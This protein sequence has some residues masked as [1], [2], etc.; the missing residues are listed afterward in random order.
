MRFS[1]DFIE[2]VSEGNNLVDIISQYT[3]LKQSGSGLMGR[4]PFPDHAEKTASFSVSEVKQVYHCFGCHKSGNLFS[5]LRDYQGMSFPEAVEY[6]ANRAS[7]PIPAP[8]AHDPQRDQAADKKKSL[9]KVNKLAADYFSEQ[10]RRVSND[11]PVKRYIASRG[12]SQ[13]VIDTFGIGYAI[14]EWD[15]LERVLQSKQ[16]PMALAEEA[17]LVKARNGKPGYFDIF[18]DRLMFPIFSP[19]GEPIAFGGRYLEKK[20]TEPKY[21]NSPETPVFIK[22]RVLYG[23]SQTARY[24]RSE[25]QALIVEG[26]MDLVSLFQAGIRNSVAT[27]GTALTPEHGK[28]L[29]RM[30]RNVVALFDGDSAG[31]EAAERSLPI[32]LSADLYPK[33]L[34]LPNSMDPDDYVKKYG[35]DALKVELDR[36]PD[37]FV[38]ILN[39]WMEG[40]RGDAPEKVKLADKLKP[41]FEVIPDQRLRDLYLAEAAQKMS[42]TL[43]WLRQAVGLQSSGPVYSQNRSSFSRTVQPNQGT[44]QANQ[45]AASQVSDSVEGGKITLKGASKA[46]ALL[47][48]LVLKSRANFELF[49]NENVLA[50]ISHAGVKKILEKATDVYRQDLNKFDKLTSLLVSYVD[51]PELLFVEAPKNEGDPGFDE[52]IEAKYLR[53]CFKRVRDNFLRDQAKQLALDAK[54]EPTSEKLE[55][56]MKAHRD[57]LSLN[58]G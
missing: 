51:H 57:R 11:H 40:Y 34:T 15:G 46:E 26:Y 4:C 39:R 16:V 10:L 9:L 2:R 55:Q 19:M 33:G 56:I 22:G 45:S 35:A 53:D 30:T 5:F 20:E 24:I 14:A 29:K 27:M 48:G 49:A 36:A 12:L 21:L 8:E 23:L 43:P 37:L 28:M 18:R 3:Q 1:Q 6:L 31:M 50:S 13:E 41:L 42:V 47:L 32:L 7:I 25:D 44:Q 38:L 54:S 17:R 52:E 58:K